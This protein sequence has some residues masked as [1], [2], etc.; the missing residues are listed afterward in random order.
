M[1]GGSFGLSSMANAFSNSMRAY[2]D[3]Q[4]Q[5]THTHN[6][7]PPPIKTKSAAYEQ[8][9]R[10]DR[11]I[12]EKRRKS[13]WNI[14]SIEEQISTLGMEKIGAM[15]GVAI[16]DDSGNE[17]HKE[18]DMFV[19]KSIRETD[20]WHQ[21][22]VAKKITINNC[23]TYTFVKPK[24]SHPPLHDNTPPGQIR[25][26]I[27]Y[28]DSSRWEPYTILDRIAGHE[29]RVALDIEGVYKQLGVP[30]NSNWYSAQTNIRS[31]DL[32]SYNQETDEWFYNNYDRLLK[33]RMDKE[34]SDVNNNINNPTANPYYNDV[35]CHRDATFPWWVEE[36]SKDVRTY[37]KADDS[38]L[39]IT[40]SNPDVIRARPRIK[41]A[42]SAADLVAFSEKN[43]ELFD[44]QVK[45]LTFIHKRLG[46][47][48]DII[49]N[50]I[51]APYQSDGYIYA[52]EYN[53]FYS[54]VYLVARNSKGP[55]NPALIKI[56]DSNSKV[57]I[58]KRFK[59]EIME[60]IDE[61]REGCEP[62]LEYL[63]D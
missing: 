51:V 45:A 57:K 20:T 38:G 59:T 22:Y 52:N 3:T 30:F 15:E 9:L 54:L 48:G 37:S 27:L 13:L 47:S 25:R 42:Y 26:S 5:D 62:L 44:K 21:I 34:D 14:P 36:D 8:K 4:T 58:H 35:K 11:D 7:P 60:W 1:F 50:N 2:S 46:P 33:P 49:N 61:V 24:C 28:I 16:L 10:N 56:T 29:Y 41:E 53:E 23:E 32:E 43:K 40:D 31:I 63:Y 19:L 39:H 6:K 17:D 12:K 18:F 55:C